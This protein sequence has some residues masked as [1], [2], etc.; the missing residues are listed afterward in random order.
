M[1]ERDIACFLALVF[2]SIMCGEVVWQ[3]LEMC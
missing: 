3:V 1:E 2:F